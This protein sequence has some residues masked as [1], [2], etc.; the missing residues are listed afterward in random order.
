MH[1][2][3]QGLPTLC[4]HFG[5]KKKDF[6]TSNIA[7]AIPELFCPYFLSFPTLLAF[8]F[9]LYI[10][11]FLCMSLNHLLMYKSHPS[12]WALLVLFQALKIQFSI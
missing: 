6:V 7:Q 5:E 1:F 8:F 3:I 10:S 12:S 9:L 4:L 2:E 11:P